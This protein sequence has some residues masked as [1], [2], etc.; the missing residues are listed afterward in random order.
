[1]PTPS[2]SHHV[3][4]QSYREQFLVTHQHQHQ[5]QK[6]SSNSRALTREESLMSIADAICPPGPRPEIDSPNALVT[7]RRGHSV[8]QDDELLH[9][10]S[11]IFDFSD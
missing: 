4:A 11:P 1:M 9:C 8:S 2:R 7:T 10:L 3:P 6:R 5:R